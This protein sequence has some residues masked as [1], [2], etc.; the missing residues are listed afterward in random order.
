[1]KKI[2]IMGAPRTG[3]TALARLLSHSAKVIITNEVGL[4]EPN[5]IWYRERIK[6]GVYKNPINVEYLKLKGLTEK[7]MTDFVNGVFTNSGNIE[8]YGDKYPTYCSSKFYC[9]RIREKH[10][11]AYFIFTYRNP[12]ATIYSGIKRSRREH[13]TTADW[14]F[15][16]LDDSIQKLITYTNNW[17]SDIFPHVDKKIIIDYDRYINN[18][19]LLVKDLNKF[20]NIELDIK[21]PEDYYGMNGRDTHSEPDAYKTEITKEYIDTITDRTRILNNRVLKLQETLK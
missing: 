10:S 14:F 9:N 19:E 4:F 2:I 3:T 21:N 13:N 8:F 5:R 6:D 20:L 12:C 17:V 16:D 1:M 15:T 7:D 11:D 18:A